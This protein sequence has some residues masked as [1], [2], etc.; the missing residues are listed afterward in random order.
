MSAQNIRRTNTEP[1]DPKQRFVGG[2]VLVLIMLFIYSTLK[3]VLGFTSASE[4][5]IAEAL[6]SETTVAGSNEG[7]LNNPGDLDLPENQEVYHRLPTGF[8][9]LSLSGKPMQ[10]DNVTEVDNSIPANDL[11]T[12][13]YSDGKWYVQAASFRSKSDAEDLV[14]KIQNQNIASKAYIL[15]RNGWYAVRLPPQE[16]RGLAKQ[17]DRQLRR[18][19]YLKP[20][21]KQI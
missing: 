2:V 8:V 9:F 4:F 13:T 20:M 18:K 17:Q 15:L 12:K 1:Y 14:Q 19:L 6:Q 5:Q 21:I 16:E 11:Y 3:I 7:T 10:P